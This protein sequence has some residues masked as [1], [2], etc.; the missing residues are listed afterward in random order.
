MFTNFKIVIDYGQ[1]ICL[2]GYEITTEVSNF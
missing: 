1:N 2:E